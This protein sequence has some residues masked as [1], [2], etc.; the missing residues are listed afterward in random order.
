MGYSIALRDDF[1]NYVFRGVAWPA[2]PTTYYIALLTTNPSDD[3]GTGAVEVSTSTW[4][5]YARQPLN[6]GT[7]DFTTVNGGTTSPQQLGNANTINYG[8][9]TISGGA[10]TVTGMAIY[11]ATTGGTFWGWQALTSSQTINNGDPV[12]FAA[13][14]ALFEA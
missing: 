6:R 9:A 10:P 4:T 13:S 3:T 11:D 14:A 2:L 8:T 1:L 5:N 12:S 7:T